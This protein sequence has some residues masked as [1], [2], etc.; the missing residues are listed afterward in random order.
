MRRN[1]PMA[2]LVGL[3]VTAALLLPISGAS[4]D[5][6]RGRPAA[7]KARYEARHDNGRDGRHDRKPQVRRD[8]RRNIHRKGYQSGRRDPCRVA[9]CRNPRHSHRGSRG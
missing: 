5:I 4:A 2:T 7:P 9:R 3:G 1:R 8:D 6:G